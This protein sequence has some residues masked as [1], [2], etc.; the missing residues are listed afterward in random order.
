MKDK[1]QI[2]YS[3]ESLSEQQVVEQQVPEALKNI[4]D[5]FLKHKVPEY[6]RYG[7]GFVADAYFAAKTS[8]TGSYKSIAKM[9]K[10]DS[11]TFQYYMEKYPDFV[12]AVN[13]GRMDGKKDRIEAVENSILSRAL[14]VEVEETRTEDSG[15][16]DEDGNFKSTY[17]K[18][19]KTKKQV[20]P[21]TQ[22][23]LE[24]LR[25]ID[26]QWNP[27]STLD[28]N[29]NSTLNVTEDVSVNV[30]LR[31]L[32]PSALKEILLS[33]KQANN[34]QINKTPDG[35]S[36]R[37]LGDRG[38]EFREKR[39]EKGRKRKLREQE[40]NKSENEEETKVVK[41]VKKRVMSPETRA[42]ISEALRKRKGG[43]KTN[44]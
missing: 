18:V 42:K 4:R 32:S 28:I 31:T 41:N 37:F 21:D 44:E 30:D 39:R 1:E 25:R 36:V 14:G 33:N 8:P 27:K 20:P 16:I 10:L 19:V 38:E 17:R 34:M 22:A 9:L 23:A 3:D 7:D 11:L 6:D 24:V 2:I 40:E 43:A 35:E 26:P 15:I 29:V 12:L 13:L 5:K